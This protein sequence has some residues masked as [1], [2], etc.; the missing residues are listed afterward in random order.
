MPSSPMRVVLFGECMIEF[1]TEAP[2]L[3]RQSFGGDTL[4]TAVY[5]ARLAGDA[6]KVS[7]ASAVGADD[8]FSA[9]M[10]ASWQA[11]GI[12][13]RYVSRRVGEL[14]G[15]YTIQVDDKGERAFSYWRQNSAARNYFPD[16]STP[17]EQSVDEVDVFYV[18][19]ISLAILPPAGRQRLFALLSSLRKSGALIVFDNNYR[20]RLW[21]CA[22]E[23]RAA[24]SQAYALAD[25]ALV[26]LSDE[27]EIDGQTDET[28]AIDALRQYPCKELVI[29]R[30]AASTLVRFAKGA[31]AGDDD[32]W[33]DIPTTPVSSVVDTTA[34][35][36]SF[37]A[38]YLSARLRGQ[39]PEAA[40]AAGNRLAATVIQYP[41]AIIPL[42]RMPA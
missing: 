36:D 30:G 10:L 4:N 41:G 34:A 11:E 9:A 1:R 20:A 31:R 40:A 21:T 2:S 17:L 39:L 18:S 27:M 7:Y 35:G 23:A 38:G 37:G 3:M 42:D 28:A 29:K 24:Y 25:I 14:P 12:D 8:P 6:Y 19:G 16:A 5:L 13:T 32:Q 33:F 15:I 26:T 22:A